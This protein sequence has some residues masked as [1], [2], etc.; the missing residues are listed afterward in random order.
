[1]VRTKF[2]Q[3]F[4]GIVGKVAGAAATISGAYGFIKDI[5]NPDQPKT[6]IEL[7]SSTTAIVVYIMLAIVA[8]CV[9]LIDK[10]KTL[11]SKNEE[12]SKKIAELN[13]ELSCAAA[14]LD[15]AMRNGQI[16]R[17]K[18]KFFLAT[19]K[20]YIDLAE[21][22]HNNISISRMR[23][24]NTIEETGIKNKRDS[25]VRM[26]I[27]AVALCKTS[28]IQILAAGDTI[29][30]WNDIKLKAYEIID[31]NKKYLN[32]RLADNGQDSYLKQVVIS[33]A[34]DKKEG[35][36]I[37]LVIE[38]MWPNML[39]IT[40]EDYTTLPI[41]LAPTTKEIEMSIEPKVQIEFKEAGI[42]KYENGMSEAELIKDLQPDHNNHIHYR[43]DTP[44]FKT[45]YI[46]YYKVSNN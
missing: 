3:N 6:F 35:D 1:M 14:R 31:G 22:I 9:F 37:N 38:W 36:I 8:I 12:L 16:A 32:A 13:L 17:F 20:L 25:H 7:I 2:W 30:N 26:Y 40:S 11:N 27:D 28:Q 24:H 34:D 23:I 21:K 42:Y 4:F 18:N 46:L 19:E 45:C 10:F 33:Y 29:V 44:C 43:D 41:V 15:S 39:D 5:I